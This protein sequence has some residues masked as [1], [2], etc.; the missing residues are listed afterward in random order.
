MNKEFF[1]KNNFNIID[2]SKS[3]I[4]LGKEKNI[5]INKNINNFN[6]EILEYEKNYFNLINKKC[7]LDNLNDNFIYFPEFDLCYCP[8]CIL[9]FKFL[10]LIYKNK[11]IGKNLIFNLKNKPLEIIIKNDFPIIIKRNNHY[12]IVIKSNIKNFNLFYPI[13]EIFKSFYNL[14]N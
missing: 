11:N 7:T 8:L 10:E 4:K 13:S 14:E 3:L 12:F 9:K 5:K 1:L 2:I 6:E